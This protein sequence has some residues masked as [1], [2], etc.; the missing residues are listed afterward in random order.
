MHT[1]WSSGTDGVLQS[2]VLTIESTQKSTFVSLFESF[3]R[4]YISIEIKY[5]PHDI[6]N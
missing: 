4:I 1:K 6:L 5:C 3:A 2:Y